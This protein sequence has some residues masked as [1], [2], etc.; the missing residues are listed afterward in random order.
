MTPAAPEHAQRILNEEFTLS[1]S[2]EV[3]TASND[4]V[5]INSCNYNQSFDTPM[6]YNKF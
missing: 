2:V 3:C 6:M 4:Y 5:L 1:L